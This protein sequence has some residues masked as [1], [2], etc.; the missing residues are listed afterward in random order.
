MTRKFTFANTLP[1]RGA[2]PPG[3]RANIC[4]NEVRTNRHAVNVVILAAGQGKRMHSDT[5]KVLHA[6]AGKP[7]LAH[8]VDTARELSPKRICVVYGHGGEAGRARV[9]E[10]HR[11]A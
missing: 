1:P 7:L 10:S 4:N 9:D 11:G 8:V 2:G 3:A 5:P 6:L